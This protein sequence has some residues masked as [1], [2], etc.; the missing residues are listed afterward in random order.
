MYKNTNA[1]KIFKIFYLDWPIGPS[2]RMKSGSTYQSSDKVV[3]SVFSFSWWSPNYW[4]VWVSHCWYCSR[5]VAAANEAWHLF[6]RVKNSVWVGP[7]EKLVESFEF[8]DL[9][10][11]IIYKIFCWH[12]N[13]RL[14]LS[15]YLMLNSLER[16]NGKGGGCSCFLIVFHVRIHEILNLE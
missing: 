7:W 15:H 11:E 16:D 13:S 5:S 1:Q 10:L 6:F 3:S 8:D 12:T 2:Y 9:G 14:N 4:R